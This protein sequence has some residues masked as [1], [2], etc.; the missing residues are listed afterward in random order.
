MTEPDPDGKMHMQ[1]AAVQ[2]TSYELWRL[3]VLQNSRGMHVCQT[4]TRD[5]PDANPHF[6]VLVCLGYGY[7]LVSGAAIQ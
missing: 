6:G 1:D 4:G 5:S 2:K 3:Q 7:K